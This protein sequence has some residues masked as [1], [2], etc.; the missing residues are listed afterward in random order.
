[1][2]IVVVG[3]EV[4]IFSQTSHFMPSKPMYGYVGV[5]HAMMNIT[6]ILKTNCIDCNCLLNLIFHQSYCQSD[7]QMS[8]WFGCLIDLVAIILSNFTLSNAYIYIYIVIPNKMG[9]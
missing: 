3:T 8:K 1:M 4:G 5:Y 9:H 6:Y 7:Y 2:D